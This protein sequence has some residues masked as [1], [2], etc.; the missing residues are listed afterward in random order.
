MPIADFDR[1]PGISFRRRLVTIEMLPDN[2]LL[3]IFDFYRMADIQ[4]L[5]GR[6]WRWHKLVHICRSWRQ[7][8]FASPLRLNMQLTCSYGTLYGNYWT[9]DHPFPLRFSM[10]DQAAT[11]QPQKM[12]VTSLLRFS[13][14]K[15][16]GRLSSL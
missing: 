12:T 4:S 1:V 2:V 8:V 7:V 10:R 14:P 11:L 16:Y 6:P 13:T 9:V 3:E 15:E 5:R